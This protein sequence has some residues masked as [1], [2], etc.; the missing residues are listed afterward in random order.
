MSTNGFEKWLAIGTGVGVEIGR[1]DLECTVVRVRPSGVSILGSLEIRRFRDQPAA[2]W[3]AVYGN[4]LKKL[5]QSHLA[6][7]V[8]LPREAVIV[9]QVPMPGVSDK[10]LAAAL[11]FQIDSLH[12]YPEEDVVSD[13]ARIGKTPA[14]LIG[15]CRRSVVDEYAA[16]FAEAGLKVSAFTFPAASLYSAVRLFGTPPADGFLALGE[17]QAEW[18]AYGESPSRP[19]FSAR[20]DE[21][22]DRAQALAL[23]ELRLPPET[24]ALALPDILPVPVARPAEYEVGGSAILY[25]TAL[26]GA[27]PWRSLPTNLLPPDLRRASSRLIYV[28]TAVLATLVVIAAVMLSAYSSYEDK[29]YLAKLQVEIQR[30]Q[31]K[32]QQAAKL[33]QRIV[34]V[35]NH[36]Q[37][38]DNFRRRLKD[39]M[40]AI[41]DLTNI[42]APPAWLNSLQLTRDAVSISGEADRAE[43]LLKMLDSSKQFRRSE[44]MLPIARGA[45]GEMFS[46]HSAREGVT[47]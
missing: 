17:H 5:G 20:M 3:G 36:A 7:H 35:R 27:C 39:D 30:M 31:P 8:L 12:P 38:L 47:P 40:N 13:F 22:Y 21:S 37:A 9:R 14:V 29:R 24:E 1:D 26:A 33:D 19:L 28:P 34:A 10:D 32:A 18:E 43:S 41:N 4:F 6:A 15:I 16:L 23:S 25:A 2:E 45:N 42:L 44:F 11:K 46:I